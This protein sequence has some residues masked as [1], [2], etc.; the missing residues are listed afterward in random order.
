MYATV[1]SVNGSWRNLLISSGLLLTAWS[2]WTSDTFSILSAAFS[3]TSMTMRWRWTTNHG[4][5]MC[6]TL[7][8]SSGHAST[9]TT[10]DSTRLRSTS[11]A[12]FG[13]T[14]RSTFGKFAPLD[15]CLTKAC[16]GAAV[17][18]CPEIVAHWPPPSDA[19]RTAPLSRNLIRFFGIARI[20]PIPRRAWPGHSAKLYLTLRAPKPVAEHG[21]L[22][23]LK[24]LL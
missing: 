14:P 12:V 6:T 24:T 15:A 13:S 18:A 1:V 16:T 9:H 4:R 5:I 17:R 20:H 21:T 19:K 2:G 10:L 22:R 8:I 11:F 23:R 7:G 3:L